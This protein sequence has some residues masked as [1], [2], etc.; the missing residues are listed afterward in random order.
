MARNTDDTH[1]GRSRNHRFSG[2]SGFDCR[3]EPEDINTPSPSEICRNLGKGSG[4]RL[5]ITWVF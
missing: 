3:D 2:S 4:C 1:G 5:V